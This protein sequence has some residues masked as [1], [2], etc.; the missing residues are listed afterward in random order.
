MLEQEKMDLYIM[1]NQ[2]YFPEE[3]IVYIK[4]K[5]CTM[6]D[7]KFTLISTVKMKDPIALFLVSIFLGIFGIDQFMI[8][9]IGMGVF[10]LLTFGGF[11][12]LTMIDWSTISQ[13]TKEANF[14]KLMMLI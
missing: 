14:N 7:E 8:G 6:D 12:I 9:N 1:T 3:K 13:K 11:G 10:K 2:N 4:D 5:L